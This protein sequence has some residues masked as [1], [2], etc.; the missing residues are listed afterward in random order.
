MKQYRILYNQDAT[1]L[2][3]STKEPLTPAH[4]DRMVDEV[5]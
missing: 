4:V 1:N 5:A 3:G 2:F